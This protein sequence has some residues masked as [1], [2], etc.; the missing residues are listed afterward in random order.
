M[1][2]LC[3]NNQVLLMSCQRSV[4][5]GNN[6]KCQQCYARTPAATTVETRERC[7]R[8]FV[9]PNC[10]GGS[11][12]PCA[13]CVCDA[14]SLWGNTHLEVVALHVQVPEPPVAKLGGQSAR[15]GVVANHPTADCFKA[16]NL[17]WKRAT[18]TGMRP[19]P[20]CA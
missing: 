15:E 13:E 9:L 3:T 12:C 17:C 10:A 6:T 5:L 11:R 8:E 1:L 18:A 14:T 16:P 20:H 2:T 19:P 4:A 7:Q